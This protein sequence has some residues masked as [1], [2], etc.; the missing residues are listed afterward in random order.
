M[1]IFW[2]DNDPVKSARY[3]VDRHV[4]KICTEIAQVLSNVHAPEVAPYRHT[5]THH[6]L[7]FWV[8]ES[9]QNYMKAAIYGKELCREYTFRYGGK[10]I[11]TEDTIDWLIEN[12]PRLPDIGETR[13]P[14]CFG[15]HKGILPETDDLVA[16]YRRFYV[17]AKSHLFCWRGRTI[18]EW[19]FSTGV[20]CPPL[21]PNGNQSKFFLE[22]QK[23]QKQN[24]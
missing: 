23:F 13:A 21:A 4:I 14:R 15:S 18:P 6:P 19:V 8:K 1:N 10:R 5:H 2:L 16:D 20:L 7:T 3:N 12:A 24:N 11:K 17:A 9:A 22:F